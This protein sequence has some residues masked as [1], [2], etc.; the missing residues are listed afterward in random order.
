LGQVRRAE[1]VAP[2]PLAPRPKPEAVGAASQTEGHNRKPKF[3]GAKGLPG[4]SSSQRQIHNLVQAQQGG[5]G[6]GWSPPPRPARHRNALDQG[7]DGPLSLGPVAPAGRRAFGGP[8]GIG[9]CH[10]VR[11]KGGLVA[12]TRWSSRICRALRPHSIG[13][14]P[15]LQSPSPTS[16]ETVGP[17][18]RQLQVQVDLGR[19]LTCRNRPIGGRRAGRV[20]A[21]VQARRPRRQVQAMGSPA[22]AKVGSPPSSTAPGTAS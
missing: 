9:C 13:P 16:V 17:Q 1:K 21:R 8:A 10:R 18:P 19:G 2:S 15:S 14:D 5:G 7:Q 3:P 4:R 6:I 11:Q 22:R 20:I 12:K